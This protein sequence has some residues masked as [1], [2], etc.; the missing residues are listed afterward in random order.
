MS[1]CVN[2][3]M[4]VYVNNV[5]QLSIVSQL[6]LLIDWFNCSLNHTNIVL[7]LYIYKSNSNFEIMFRMFRRPIRQ[8]VYSYERNIKMKTNFWPFLRFGDELVKYLCFGTV[9]STGGGR[10]GL[11]FAGLCLTL[12]FVQLF[13]RLDLFLQ[14]HSSVLE[15]DLDLPFGQ[16]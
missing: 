1:E 8:I 10:V 16:T 2:V 6:L 7:Y 12:L 14:F 11:Q 15:P 5:S 3:L 9:V 13:D 4:C